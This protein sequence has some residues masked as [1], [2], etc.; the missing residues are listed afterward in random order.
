[1]VDLVTAKTWWTKAAEAG[2]AYAMYRLGDCLEN[3]I[4]V[5]NVNLDDAFKWYRLAAQNGY[6]DAEEACARFSKSFTGKVKLKK[7]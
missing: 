3:G 1:M 7:I 5:S 2:D 4:G 6:K